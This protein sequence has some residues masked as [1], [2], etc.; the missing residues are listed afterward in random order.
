MEVSERKIEPKLLVV[1]TRTELK[2]KTS[3]YMTFWFRL[4]VRVGKPSSQLN[5]IISSFFFVGALIKVGREDLEDD[6]G[7]EEDEKIFKINIVSRIKFKPLA[8]TMHRL[9][10]G[11][12]SLRH[13]YVVVNS[14]KS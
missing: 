13:D 7:V 6:D 3:A 5:E 4:I 12:K 11:V 2:E 9:C 10:C 8:Y 1:N 14:A